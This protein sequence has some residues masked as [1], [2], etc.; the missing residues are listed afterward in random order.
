[1]TQ[2]GEG[3]FDIV[4]S[5]D[6][7]NFISTEQ[8]RTEQSSNALLENI[9][10]ENNNRKDKIQNEEDRLLLR[11]MMFTDQEAQSLLQTD[12]VNFNAELHGW[13]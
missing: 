1:M 11:D 10:K 6:I 2:Y 9:T 7:I 12:L 3:N 5:Q 4:T 13:I 8:I